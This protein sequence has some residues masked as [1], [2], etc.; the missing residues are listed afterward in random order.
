MN[1][2]KL[3]EAYAAV[4]DEDLRSELEEMSDEFAGI[5]ELTEEEIEAIVEETIDEMIEDGIDFDDVDEIFEEVL[6]EA[7]VTMGRGGETGTGG[8]RVTT[9][10]GSRMAAAS[11]L[12]S[13]KAAKRAAKVA[14]VKASVKQKV[15]QVKAAPKEASKSVQKKVKDVKQQSHVGMAKYANKRGLMGGAGLKTQSSKG[16]SELR[17]AVAKDIKGRIKQ[18]IAKAQVGAYN[19][20]RSAGQAASDTAARAKQSAKNTAARTK[21]GIKG[22]IRGAAERVASGAS[23]LAQRMSEE[24]DIYD[25][26]LEHLIVEGYADT[27]ESAESI[28]VNMSEEWRDSIIE[29][30]KD[31]P[32]AKVVNKAG[33]LM[34]SSAGKSDSASKKKEQRGIKMM[35]VTMQHTPDR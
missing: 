32:T 25:L 14:Q 35:D 27:I 24:F 7:T 26:I 33:K 23:R 12:S 11:R 19:A 21:R 16:R 8:S 4:Y 10:S 34:G 18:K 1:P 31:F 20:A 5:E 28:M 22:A 30:Y 9:G 2:V 3:Y 17:S 6:S 13:A 29:E 15:A